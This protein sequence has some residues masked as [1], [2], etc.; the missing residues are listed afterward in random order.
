MAEGHHCSGGLW[1]EIKDLK[2]TAI[3]TK[4]HRSY[5][6]A[7]KQNDVDSW[8]CN[9]RADYYAKQGAK[10]GATTTEAWYKKQVKVRVQLTQYCAKVLAEW[11]PVHAA[12]RK[13]LKPRVKDPT[14]AFSR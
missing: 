11:G 5:S 8:H 10:L 14:A 9:E 6:E 3:K 13:Q 2:V 12:V 7:V 4:A 1:A